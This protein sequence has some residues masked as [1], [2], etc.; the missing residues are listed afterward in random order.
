MT[1]Y[2]LMPAPPDDVAA[3]CLLYCAGGLDAFCGE[4]PLAPPR[5]PDCMLL[6]AAFSG[7]ASVRT[8]GKAWR[9][10]PGGLL[11]VLAEGGTL[12]VCAE[13]GV[14]LS[15]AWAL[16]GGALPLRW[17]SAGAALP[18]MPHGPAESM[19]R[20]LGQTVAL[21]GAADGFWASAQAYGLLMK[22]RQQAARGAHGAPP[23]VEEA[24]A[25][26]RADFAYLGGVEDVA[27][28][29]GVSKSHLIRCFSA[30]IGVPPGKYLTQVRMEHAKLLLQGGRYPLE[31]VAGMV[32]VSG[33][34]YF[35][36]LFK[37]YTGIT[38]ATYPS[39]FLH[40][41]PHAPTAP[42]PRFYL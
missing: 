2:T 39:G 40:E 18:A 22:L 25:L 4:A 36:K 17:L 1:S 37:A 35:C 13:K 29:L 23:L 19:L 5:R 9:V 8:G 38:P 42:D 26:I 10:E 28:R 6:F 11:C 31:T 30:H 15:C 14:P 41:T 33:A 24:A 21:G 34:N 12:T 3:D 7:A 32:G 20:A 27:D 16:L